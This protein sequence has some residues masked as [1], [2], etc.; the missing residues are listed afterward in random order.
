LTKKV[1]A[2]TPQTDKAADLLKA[3]EERMVATKKYLETLKKTADAKIAVAQKGKAV[4]E[5]RLAIH[6]KVS[7]VAKTSK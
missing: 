4:A 1:D 7:E 2:L 5:K 6:A 3:G